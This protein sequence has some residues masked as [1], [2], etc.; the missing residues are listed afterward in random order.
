MFNRTSKYCGLH[1]IFGPNLFSP[2]VL[3]PLQRGLSLGWQ[4]NYFVLLGS[5]TN[6][7]NQFSTYTKFCPEI[8]ALP[9]SF[10]KLFSLSTA[11]CLLPVRLLCIINLREI[12]LGSSHYTNY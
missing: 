3:E 6:L 1:H 5:K 9:V 7:L 12:P 8:E 2:L 10:Q 11:K 4:H